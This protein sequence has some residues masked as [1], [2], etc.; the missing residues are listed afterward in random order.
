MRRRLCP[1]F[2]SRLEK[3]TNTIYPLWYLFVRYYYFLSPLVFV[4][5]ILLLFIP[6]GI[7]LCDIIIFYPLWY[8][9]VRYYYYLSLLIFVCAILSYFWGA[10]GVGEDVRACVCACVCVCVCAFFQNFLWFFFLCVVRVLICTPAES[11]NQWSGGS[12]N[13]LFLSKK[14]KPSYVHAYIQEA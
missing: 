2:L 6:F 14:T 11:L 10:E 12:S 7:C 9:F 8:L 1:N 3:R 5:A 13:N 4:C